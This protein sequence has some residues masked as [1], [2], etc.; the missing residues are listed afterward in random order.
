M[1]PLHESSR[2]QI[3]M[4][5]FCLLCIAPTVGVV[6]WAITWRLPS[7]LAAERAAIAQALGLDVNISSMRHVRPGVVAYEDLCLSDP[8]NGKSILSCP[9]MQAEESIEVDRRG[10]EHPALVL[11]ASKMTIVASQWSKVLETLQRRLQGVGGGT[12]LEIRFNV[13]ELAVQAGAQSQTLYRI[14]AGG[15]SGTV[16]LLLGFQ[17]NSRKGA[18]AAVAQSA[19]LAASQWL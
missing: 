8:E 5:L 19:D 2:R 1:F 12:E 7:H 14:E 10:E 16:R 11:Q 15:S 13:D 9:R 17:R 3:A 18:H 6:G 4:L